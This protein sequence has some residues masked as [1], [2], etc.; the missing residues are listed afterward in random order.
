MLDLRMRIIGFGILG[1]AIIAIVVGLGSWLLRRDSPQY[2]SQPTSSTMPTPSSTN[3]PAGGLGG[4]PSGGTL[5]T[6][7]STPP[8]AP[9]TTPTPVIDRTQRVERGTNDELLSIA[10]SFASVYGSFSS[11]GGF[12]NLE[13]LRFLMS[14]NMNAWADQLIKDRKP[15]PTGSADLYYGMATTTLSAAI[16][17]QQSD[18]TVIFVQTQRKET[19]GVLS[20]ARYLLEDLTITF[21]REEGLWKVESAVWSNQRILG[22]GSFSGYA[23]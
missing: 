21:V 2:V 15:T 4:S 10:Y 14:K 5:P 11:T 23:Q 6:A 22:A 13:R 18:R 8:P 16:K 20:N 7:T 19:R 3:V 17:Q 1:S 12:E 9:P